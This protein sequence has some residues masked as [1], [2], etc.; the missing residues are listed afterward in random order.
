MK[1]DLIITC[2]II[3][4]ASGWLINRFIKNFKARRA[5]KCAGGCGCSEKL[6]PKN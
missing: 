2:F 3:G 6:K 4:V 5:G 1:T